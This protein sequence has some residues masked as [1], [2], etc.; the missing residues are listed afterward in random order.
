MVAVFGNSGIRLMPT[1]E[2]RARK[3]LK[4]GRA[5][6]HKH[7]PFTIRLLDRETGETQP[8][9]YKTD[10]GYGHV[11]VSICS[12]K[13]EYVS[14]QYDLLHDETERH[15]D[16]W[17]Y[18]RARRNRRRYRA[19]RFDNRRASKKSGWLAPSIRN[20]METQV[21]LFLMYTQVYPITNAVF[22]MGKFDTQLLKAIAEGRT[23]PQGVDYQHGERYLSETLRQAVFSRDGYTCRICGRGISDHAILHEHHIGYWKGD[24]TNRMANLMTVCEKCHTPGNHKPFGKLYGLDPKLP[25]FKGA[26]FMTIVRWQ[27]CDILREVSRDIDIHITYGAMTKLKRQDLHIKKSHVNDAYATGTLHPAHRADTLYRR[28][29]RRNNRVLEKFYDAKLIDIRDGKKKPGSSLGCNR[30]NRREPRMSDKNE[31]VF[32]GPKVSAG[33]R[34]I[35]RAHYHIQPGTILQAGRQ[36]HLAKGVHCGG[37]RVILDNGKSVAI[38]TVKVVSYPGAWIAVSP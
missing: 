1:T 13:H 25:A 16:C 11:G 21:R 24:R 7:V 22:E 38:H 28:K 2:A 23:A 32:R 18:R 37:S 8:V 3:L 5:V 19:P 17:K 20:R 14:A 15:N 9:E 10:T 31:R 34:V 36:R 29:R 27:M 35:R 4:S 33:K 30:T 6:I 26:T 12:G